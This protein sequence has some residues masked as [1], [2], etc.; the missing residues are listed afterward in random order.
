MHF[1]CPECQNPIEAADE[2]GLEEVVCPACGSAFPLHAPPT[3]DFT[4]LQLP[5]HQPTIVPGQVISHYRIEKRLG[6]GGM[7]L[8][9]KALDTRL[10]RTVALKFLPERLSHDRQALERFRREARTASALNHPHICTIHDIDEH[11]GQPF[12]VMELLE[13]ETLKHRIMGKPLPADELLELA[14]QIAEAL[15]AAHAKGILH[16]DIKPS[17]IFITKSGQVKVLDF[18]LAKLL[19]KTALPS[20]PLAPAE[21]GDD[22]LSGPGT[23]LGTVAYMSP[24]QA[25]GQNLDAR[26]DLFAFG[27][28]LYEMATGRMAFSGHTSAVIFDAILN[29]APLSPCEL[30]PALPPELEHIIARA[31]EKDRDVR[32]QTA[33]DLRADLKRL[34]RFIE[35]G[36][37]STPSVSLPA[38]APAYRQRRRPALAVALGVLL[39]A[40]VVW[41]LLGLPPFGWKAPAPPHDP[42]WPYSAAPRITPFLTGEAL[43][44]QPAWSP[45]GPF[46]AYVSNEAGRDDVWVCDASG[47]SGGR[48]LTADMPGPCSH[49]AWSPTGQRIAFFSE[50]QGGGGIYSMPVLGGQVRKLISVSSGI[51]YSFGLTWA[52]DGR[53]VYTDFDD[54]GKKQ[55]FAVTEFNPVRECLTAKVEAP[56]GHFGELSPS[57]DLLAFLDAGINLTAGLYIGNMRSGGFSKLEQGV[58]MPHWGP[59]GNRLFFISARESGVD[60]WMVRV[61]PR[62][63]EKIGTARRLTSA[64]N[65]TD[66][67]LSPAGYKLLAVKS[68]SQAQLWSFPAQAER[69]KDFSNGSPLTQGRFKDA[70]P[71]ATADAK[72]VLFSSNRRGNSE[73]WQLEQ[74]GRLARVTES[75]GNKEH[76]CL[77]PDGRW[78]AFTLVDEVGEY[79]HVMRSTGGSSHLLDPVLPKEYAAAY[80]ADWSPNSP[81]LAAVFESK[82]RKGNIGI[83]TMDPDSGLARETKL[84][85]HLPGESPHCPRWSPNGRFIVYE[86]VSHGNW[87][88]WIMTSDGRDPHQLTSDPGN[89]R[90]ATW[91]RD[92]KYLYYIKDQRS[93]WRLP[94]DQRLGHATGKPELWAEFPKMKIA[95]DSLAVTNDQVIISV[96]EEA[97]DLWLVEFPEK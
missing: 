2:A 36:R 18:G 54:V 62:T 22:D 67:T 41:L 45:T 3:Q 28:V 83:V 55:V 10:G 73:L 78:I 70:Y 5:Q 15:E 88:L 76:P 40:S 90:T 50:E 17:N 91:S 26:T 84:L 82:R 27:A 9:F 20:L 12:I 32:Y 44:R 64:Q 60:L 38:V 6:G 85:G 43:R 31:L 16:R 75:P 63:G 72:T 56:D 89:M 25:R 7:G 46:I 1:L 94:M 77:S 30:N 61:D 33:S 21:N 71:Y 4:L 58:A 34:K 35:T 92:G 80:H 96:T 59:Q 14:I 52:K 29:K 86:A 47:T 23:V 87:D 69:I 79:L 97:S 8:V 53:I 51:L 66:F 11:A 81:C 48:N 24:E 13:G 37:G 93:V 68:N 95:W 65:I 49:P 39:A 74:G 57:G 42:D 19:A